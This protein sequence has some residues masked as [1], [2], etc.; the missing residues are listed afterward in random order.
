MITEQQ[1]RQMMP[2]AGARLDAH[3]PFINPAIEVARITTPRR[4]AAFLAQLAHESGEYRYMEEGWGP[5]EAQLGYEGRVDLGN[6]YAGDGPKFK[7][8]GPI[9]ITGRTNHDACGR[10][11]GL[12]LLN[13]PTLITLPEHGT[14]SACWFWNTRQLSLLADRDWFKAITRIINGGYN[15]LADRVRYWDRNR[16]I[17]GL[18]HVNPDFE[19]QAIAAFQREHGLMADGAVGPRT[20]AAVKAAP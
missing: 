8:H 20:L 16:T 18:P 10:S 6:V 9:Q 13:N 15:G 1:F 11:L 5:T 17:L 7:G 2:L 19:E 3:W 4:I 12:D 14:A